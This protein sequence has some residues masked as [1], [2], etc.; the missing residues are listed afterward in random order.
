MD[1]TANG[2]PAPEIDTNA[3]SFYRWARRQECFDDTDLLRASVETGLS[4]VSCRDSISIL[5]R[6]DLLRPAFGGSLVAAGPQ[7]A[8]AVLARVQAELDQGEAELL[9]RRQRMEKTRTAVHSVLP[10]QAQHNPTEILEILPDLHT[11][12]AVVCEHMHRSRKELSICRPGGGHSASA[13]ADVLLRELS[14]IGRQART[15]IVY[16]HPARFHR[17]TQNQAHEASTTGSEIRTTGEL[18]GLMLVIDQEVAFLP[19]QEHPEGVVMVRQ[20]SV[21]GYLA[22]AFEVLWSRST[23]FRSGPAAART[24]SDE[25]RS[26]MLR[27]LADGLKDEVIA[28]RLGLSLRTCRRHISELY[29]H[30]GADSRFQAGVL[31]ERHGLT[32]RTEPLTASRTAAGN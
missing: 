1:T 19:D 7:A 27:L 2:I 5:R 29:R 26:T 12:R 3:I 21:V 16:Q 14:P 32:H 18:C 11:A 17:H 28:R 25:T 31:A 8:S 20:P 24:V 9:A 6:W 10:A 30:L 4:T 23:P 22:D 15:R 13:L